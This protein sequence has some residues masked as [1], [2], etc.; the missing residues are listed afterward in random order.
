MTESD[1]ITVVAAVNDDRVLGCNLL[2]SPDLV[3]PSGRQLLFQRGFRSASQAYNAAF[4]EAEHD[5][6]VFVHQDVFLP[7]GWFDMLTS[8][9]DWLDA[10]AC[11]WGVLGS[12]GSARQVH[13]GVGRVFT[14]GMGV[15]GN[16]IEVPAPVETLDEIVLVLRKSSPLRFDPSLPHF[17]LYGSD[18]CLESRRLGLDAYAIPAPCVHNTNQ[19]LQLPREFYACYR[20]LKR[21]W[22]REL[23]IHAS[24]MTISRFDLQMRR[25]QAEEAWQ[26]LNIRRRDPLLRAD[27]PSGLAAFNR[28]LVPAGTHPTIGRR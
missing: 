3:M 9:V 11:R 2:R 17:H 19:V 20:H 21:K 27:D 18:I 24:C 7:A 4:D 25:R 8:A 5:L 23:P 10:N 16:S 6:V 13:G 22:P 26:R 15:H 1:D 28:R 14:T 12:F